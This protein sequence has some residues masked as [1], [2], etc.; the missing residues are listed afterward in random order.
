[1]SNSS[2]YA[3]DRRHLFSQ[4]N[5]LF[6]TL[7]LSK[8][9]KGDDVAH[10]LAAL[11]QERGNTEPEEALATSGG[12]YPGLMAQGTGILHQVGGSDS[13]PQLIAYDRLD[14]AVKDVRAS[15]LRNLL[16]RAVENRYTPPQVGCDKP[17]PDAADDP[18]IE[19][20]Q[21]PH[22]AD[23]LFELLLDCVQ[24]HGEVGAQKRDRE[25]TQSMKREAKGEGLQ[26]HPPAAR[27]EHAELA[28][29]HEPRIEDGAQRRAQDRA[30][31]SQGEARIDDEEE[32]KGDK[33]AL[34]TARMGYQDR[35]QDQVPR[36]LQ[37]DLERK[38]ISVPPQKQVGSTE[39]NGEDV[40]ERRERKQADAQG[41]DIYRSGK[42]QAQ[43]NE[44]GAPADQ[45]EN[46]SM[47]L[48]VG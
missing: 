1:M 29:G 9:L 4:S 10:R 43:K 26:L 7:Y 47:K 12:V 18:F 31:P 33:R 8:V 11:I 17:A 5:L 6:K 23:L 32:I 16:R 37:I 36:E 21:V 46:L 20:L 19:S 3:S 2:G 39:G 14:R 28:R 42:I 25:E 22:G 24:A 35:R 15:L 41:E 40:E 44:Y 30:D 45:P 34:D 38:I 13:G 27:R 48:I